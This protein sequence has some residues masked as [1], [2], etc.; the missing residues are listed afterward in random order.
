[1]DTS[2][3]ASNEYEVERLLRKRVR[4]GG[5]EYLVKWAGY[6]EAEA[7]WEPLSSLGNCI[8]M[9]REF[10]RQA[11]C[12]AVKKRSEAPRTTSRPTVRPTRR[13]A[14]IFLAGKRELAALLETGSS[15]LV[16]CLPRGQCVESQVHT[17]QGVFLRLGSRSQGIHL[18]ERDCRRLF[19]EETRAHFAGPV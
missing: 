9:V 15:A 17:S 14:A 4:A 6:S 5:D 8:Q 7:S 2:Q 1:M 13:P 18:L 16:F 3:S 19:P 11:Q 12:Q 10:D